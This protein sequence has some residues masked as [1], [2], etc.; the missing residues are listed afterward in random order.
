MEADVRVLPHGD[1]AGT[2]QHR[3]PGMRV[4]AKCGARIAESFANCPGCGEAQPVAS[5]SE[6]SQD[7]E[8][9][10]RGEGEGKLAAAPSSFSVRFL[11]LQQLAESN[12]PTYA[13]KVAQA[14]APYGVG[15]GR[16]LIEL[17]RLAKG[18]KGLVKR[19]KAAYPFEKRFLYMITEAGICELRKLRE[20]QSVKDGN[21][22]P[23]SQPLD[24]YLW[25]LENI[26][27]PATIEDLAK[28]RGDPRVTLRVYLSQL[29]KL[30]I[31]DKFK[32]PEPVQ[33]SQRN[34]NGEIVERSTTVMR[35]YYQL[36]PGPLRDKLAE[37]AAIMPKA[38][39]SVKI[40]VP[41]A[42]QELKDPVFTP[43]LE[44]EYQQWRE[45]IRDRDDFH[46][47]IIAH[48]NRA[49]VLPKTMYRIV[50]K[51]LKEQGKL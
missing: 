25:L 13:R 35:T 4:C 26:V 51:R 33:F 50:F 23:E 20:R 17:N 38:A 7:C 12:A 27:E 18:S 15:M 9:Q 1:A 22:A 5:R 11:I 36:R 39:P 30:G 34:R 10:L 21:S 16:V 8:R 48:A 3:L 41:M 49:K 46:R 31:I 45:D 37:T 40:D 42:T 28:L 43:K 44:E 47:V 6:L 29:Y 2:G 24:P 14:L 32:Q 19:T